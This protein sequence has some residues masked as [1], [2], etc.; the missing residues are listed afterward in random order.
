MN[1]MMDTADQTSG[2]VRL[3]LQ[4]PAGAP[5]LRLQV[6]PE[7][8]TGFQF[9]RIEIKPDVTATLQGLRQPVPATAPLRIAPAGV[10]CKVDTLFQGGLRLVDLKL[11][12]ASIRRGAT[13]GVDFQFLFEQPDLDLADLAVFVHIV[14]A[15]GDIVLQGDYGLADLLD[16]YAPRLTQPMPWQRSIAVPT[17]TPPGSYRIR[18]GL[19]RITTTDRLRIVASPHPYHVKAVELPVEFR[20]TD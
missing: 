7:T 10:T 6:R 13:L 16:L 1:G 8:R 20:V 15:A 5:E 18:I 3:A 19:C 9:S 14:N 11:S 17:G 12:A 4:V 2:R